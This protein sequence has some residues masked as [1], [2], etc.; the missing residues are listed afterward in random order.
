MPGAAVARVRD[1]RRQAAATS[2]RRVATRGCNAVRVVRHQ[3]GRQGHTCGL[4]VMRGNRRL[5]DTQLAV[6]GDGRRDAQ[7]AL[8][9]DARDVVLHRTGPDLAAVEDACRVLGASEQRCVEHIL[10]L[11]TEDR[12]D[13]R[14]QAD[15]H[16]DAVALARDVPEQVRLATGLADDDALAALS[17]RQGVRCDRRTGRSVHLRACR[18]DTERQRVGAEHR[19][20]RVAGDRGITSSRI[21]IDGRVRERRRRRAEVLVR[22]AATSGTWTRTSGWSRRRHPARPAGSTTVRAACAGPS[23][24]TTGKP[25]RPPSRERR[26]RL[27]PYHRALYEPSAPGT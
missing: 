26:E 5:R 10:V 18:G 20:T 7:V 8:Q 24:S 22:V 12:V 27:E 9:T 14:S 16:V 19:V 2:G 4:A 21:G 1:S 15:R 25:G 23:G 6:L 17:S 11:D 3:A 13:R